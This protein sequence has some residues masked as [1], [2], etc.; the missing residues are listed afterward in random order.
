V[1]EKIHALVGGF[2]LAPAPEDYLRQGFMAE[3]NKFDSTRDADALQR[4]ELC[5]SGEKEMPEKLVLC[6]TGSSFTFTA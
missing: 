5:R 2:Y 1:V 4:P 3:L 6:G